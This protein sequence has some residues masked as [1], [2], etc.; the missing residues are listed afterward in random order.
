VSERLAA[1]QRAMRETGTDLV[2]VGPSANLRY[3]LGY[4]PLAGDR[5]TTL[6]VTSTNAVML[7]PDFDVDEFVEATGHQRTVPWSDKLGP[8]PAV[9]E[10]FGELDNLP[11][12]PVVR[13]DD[14][15]PFAFLVHLRERLGT[16]APG[17]AGE[18]L[19][20]L[21]L[22]KTS[23]EQEKIGRAGELVSVGIDVALDA[24]E[25][26]VTEQQLAATI[27]AALR[28]AGAETVDYVLVAGGPGS[29]AP[30]Q[31]AGARR[32]QAGETVLVDIAGRL[33]GYFAD[34]TQQVF[35][36][37][38]PAEYVQ[39]YETVHA[40]QEAGVEAARVGATA[41]DV[42]RAATQVIVE[43]GLG[44]WSGPRTG[45][46]LG[47]D[48]HEPPSVVEGD[49]TELRPGVVI[50]VEPGV[51]IPGQFGIRIED[52]VLVTEDGPK[53][54]TRGSRPLAVK[55]PAAG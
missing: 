51:Y 16:A 1:L 44:E 40:A 48:V 7:M 32:L 13:V 14:E 41:H 39:A 3:L 49:R 19:G 4:R 25:P 42:D 30:H 10:A 53:R 12:D 26:G 45:H 46:G 9:A 22:L 47:L 35:L 34:I 24:A 21:R 37:E 23:E 43:A 17:L 29:A 52:T 36:G 50:T 18:L 33:D 31:Q 20:E 55:R 6:L 27:D 2:V 28:G 38:P 15:L 11:E 8:A 5:I 54:L